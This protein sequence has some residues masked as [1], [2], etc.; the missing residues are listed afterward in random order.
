MKTHF[1]D[2]TIPKGGRVGTIQTPNGLK[3]GNGRKLLG[4]NRTLM[5]FSWPAQSGR[6]PVRGNDESA[7][8][9]SQLG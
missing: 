2:E 8:M 9:M 5:G 6:S 3:N 7:L 4:E 1:I